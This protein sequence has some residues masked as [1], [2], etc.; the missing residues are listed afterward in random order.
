M[1]S[2]TIPLLTTPMISTPRIVPTIEPRPPARLAPPST[3][4]VIAENSSPVAALPEP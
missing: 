3:T 2:S 1:F 4:A